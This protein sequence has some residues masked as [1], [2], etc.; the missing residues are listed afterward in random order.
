MKHYSLI[1]FLER[2]AFF[3]P[4]HRGPLYLYIFDHLPEKAFAYDED[5][6][7]QDYE[8]HLLDKEIATAIKFKVAPLGQSNAFEVT[9]Q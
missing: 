3:T 6:A 9:V 5:H 1:S 4:R 8:R 7:R 2:H